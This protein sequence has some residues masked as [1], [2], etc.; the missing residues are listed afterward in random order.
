MERIVKKAIK[1]EI[2]IYAIHTALDN[3]SR[4]VSYTLA[5]ALGLSN[6]QVLVPQKNTLKQF[7]MRHTML[8]LKMLK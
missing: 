4:G 6:V 1:N 3:Q 7:F 2:A 5:N 8:I